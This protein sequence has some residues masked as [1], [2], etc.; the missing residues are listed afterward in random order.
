MRT[1]WRFTLDRSKK[2]FLAVNLT[3]KF[4]IKTP[5]EANPLDYMEA[6]ARG[7]SK[8]YQSLGTV[9]VMKENKKYLDRNCQV[10]L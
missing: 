5:Q 9:K 8:M 1:D 7:I 10:L 6:D 2:S 4:Y 3:D